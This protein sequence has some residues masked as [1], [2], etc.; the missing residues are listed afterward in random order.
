MGIRSLLQASFASLMLSGAALYAYTLRPVRVTVPAVPLPPAPSGRASLLF[1]QG[2]AY[3]AP[4]SGVSG[5]P[6]FRPGSYISLQAS[7]PFWSVVD[8]GGWGYAASPVWVFTGV[9]F[10]L[11]AACAFRGWSWR[12]LLVTAILF[13]LLSANPVAVVMLAALLLHEYSVAGRLAAS[14]PAALVVTLPWASF[15]LLLAAAA[16]AVLVT[17][18]ARFLR[19]P[20]VMAAG[21][22]ASVLLAVSSAMMLSPPDPGPGDLADC[23]IE[24][25]GAGS[26]A[27]LDVLIHRC[28]EGIMWQW[29]L[30]RPYEEGRSELS[31]GL[32]AVAER[33]FSSRRACRVGEEALSEA[34]SL[35]DLSSL[36]SGYGSLCDFSLP[37]GI[38]SYAAFFRADP[39]VSGARV[40]GDISFPLV[41][42]VMAVSQCWHGVGQGAARRYGYDLGRVVDV[43]S[44][45]P[46]DAAVNNCFEGASMS[47]ATVAGADESLRGVR[48]L[49]LDAQ[50]CEDIDHRMVSGCYRYLFL[51]EALEGRM[52]EALEGVSLACRSA[53]TD[54]VADCWAAVGSTGGA[55]APAS[56]NDVAERL[57]FCGAAPSGEL[58][59]VCALRLLS[60]ALDFSR[61]LGR[62]ELL[63]LLRQEDLYEVTSGL[64]RDT[65]SFEG[66]S[67]GVPSG[68]LPG[69]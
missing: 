32:L 62:D 52:V 24:A 20:A 35:R 38:G 18:A 31:S 68:A 39:S 53:G 7:P 61:G 11:M 27:A 5:G 13:S 45:A 30:A 3:G 1:G 14:L 47:A 21:A 12:A 54:R 44:A 4:V 40:C 60:A 26:Q 16:S 17:A 58:R 43:C 66:R 57:E 9:L 55:G 36:S 65:S 63:G 8:V 19:P 37:H 22:A 64:D 67:T 10:V 50:D 23:L 34:A 48:L 28:S 59:R 15:S 29:G 46:Y 69:P 2:I 25:S 49:P 41:P 51:A 33:G 42:E 6:V 56:L